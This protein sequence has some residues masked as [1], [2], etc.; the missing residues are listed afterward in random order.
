MLTGLFFLL[1]AGFKII[2]LLLVVLF[3]FAAAQAL[4]A[5][6]HRPVR[7]LL[8]PRWRDLLLR[9]GPCG[10][11]DVPYLVSFALSLLVSLIWFV[12]RKAAWAWLLQDILGAAVCCTFLRSIRL[13]S[14]RV[15]AI[16]L[17]LMFLYDIFMVFLSP[18][19]FKESVMMSVATAGEPS[20]SISP[21]GECDRFEGE[22]MP[23]LFLVPRM[24]RPFAGG[25]YAML[26]LGDVVIPG[27]LLTLAA[28][29]DL[30]AA[31]SLSQMRKDHTSRHATPPLDG[32]WVLACVGYSVG[33]AL[34]LLANVFH[35][36]LF[37][38]QGQ[39]ALLYLV[40]CTLGPTCLRARS[41]GELFSLWSGAAIEA[42]SP[43]ASS[44]DPQQHP[45]CAEYNPLS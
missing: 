26:G 44:S 25:D 43:H 40:P 16:L 11:F 24:A 32:Y 21:T 33:L 37:G 15:A 3:S 12:C 30:A 31:A 42:P 35:V 8:P 17:T 45:C 23:M 27:L 19:I 38:V 13:P 5:L 14:L 36:T 2:L 34:A 39:P 41:R 29:V 4:T 9:C 10:D 1:Q 28:R 20:A 6:A 18:L 22:R 7:S